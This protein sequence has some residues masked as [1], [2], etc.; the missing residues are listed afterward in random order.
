MVSNKL[1]VAVSVAVMLFSAGALAEGGVTIVEIQRASDEIAQLKAQ[2]AVEEVRFT[3]E[4]KRNSAL[5][6]KAEQLKKEE[7]RKEKE[8]EKDSTEPPPSPALI[9]R[10]MELDIPVAVGVKLLAI[11]GVGSSLIAVVNANGAD[12]NLRTGDHLPSGE[13]ISEIKPYSVTVTK[14]YEVQAAGNGKKGGKPGTVT[15]KKSREIFF[16]EGGADFGSMPVMPQLPAL[17]QAPADDI[18]VRIK[19]GK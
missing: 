11:Q 15:K 3:L 12:I 16:S 17:P 14:I 9:Q 2:A 5:G 19:P 18:P 8:K 7:E 4:E 6:K 10:Q 1:K 13:V